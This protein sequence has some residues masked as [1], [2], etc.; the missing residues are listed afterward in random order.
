LKEA[1]ARSPDDKPLHEAMAI[2]LLSRP[3]AD[4]SLIGEHLRRSFSAG[5]RNFEARFN[6]AQLLFLAGDVP[7][8][9]ALFEEIDKSAPDSFRRAT[10]ARDN[11][12][13]KRMSEVTGSVQTVKGNFLF[14]RSAAY[15]ADIFAHRNLSNY[16]DFDDLEIGQEVSFRIRFNRTGPTAVSVVP[17]RSK[18]AQVVP[19]VTVAS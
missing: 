4:L 5:D 15:P 16:D 2:H 13:T 18:R 9:R 1:L 7:N 14:I 12:F 17:A 19:S 3:D 10:P 6:L 8:S 11:L